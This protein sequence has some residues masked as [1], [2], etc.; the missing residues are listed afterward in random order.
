VNNADQKARQHEPQSYFGIDAG[1]SCA[2][3]YGATIWVRKCVNQ[4]EKL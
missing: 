2:V 1:P 3:D 4:D